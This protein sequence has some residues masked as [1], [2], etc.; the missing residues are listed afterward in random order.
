MKSIVAG[1]NDAGQRMDKFMGKFFP[2]MP[3]SFL[4]KSL[5]KNCVKVNG[6]RVAQDY[7]LCAGDVISF[8]IKDEFFQDAAPSPPPH[9]N[10]PL[11]IVYEDANILLVNKPAG[12]PVHA[13]G[14]NSDTL[15]ARL[16]GY[17]TRKGEYQAEQEHTFAPALC[18]RIDRN[19]SGIVIA[20]KNAE[21]LRIM[22]QKIKDR[23]VKKRYLCVV[24]GVLPNRADELIGYL[25]K[26]ERLNKVYVT[27]KPQDGARHII[28]RYR[29]LAHEGDASLLEVE[30]VTGRSH[31]IRAHLASIGHP[32]V[33]DA[34]YG[35]PKAKKDERQQQYQALCSYQLTFAFTTDA[36]CL[37]NVNGKTFTLKNV[38]FA[39]RFNYEISN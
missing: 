8:Y 39:K 14:S 10:A 17:L 9:T 5:R 31:Q 32:L 27:D 2:D 33:G 16:H 25:H 4:Y 11:D 28:T 6:K 37:N 3:K 26:N 18:N 23:E 21:A 19:T 7:M 15:I 35:A 30:L 24:H 20:A 34:K 22:N 13:G 29:V 36:G 38:D 1:Q 12:L